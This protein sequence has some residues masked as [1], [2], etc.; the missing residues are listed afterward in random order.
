M[1]QLAANLSTTF[2]EVPLT[3]RFARAAAAG[4]TAAELQFP[5]DTPAE[6]IAAA[7]RTARL[8]IVLI[9]APAGD[10]A[11]GERG[12][13][14][15]GG[16]RFEA[17][18]AHAIA[19]ATRL[20]CTRIHVLIGKHACELDGD[21]LARTA[22]NLHA[23][24][25]AMAQNGITLLLEALNP[26]NEPGYALLSLHAADA[27]RRAT[28]SP[29]VQLQFDAYHAQRRGEDPVASLHRFLPNIAHVQIARA[30]DRAEPDDPATTRFLAALDATAYDGF[31]GCEYTPAGDTQAGLAWAAPYGIR[32][33]RPPI[34][35]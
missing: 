15:A 6:T 26:H 33:A 1:L 30:P 8:A 9:N 4:F 23:A 13:A 3:Q 17:A 29:N 18:I 7:A 2:R 22:A 32:P 10:L 24:A 11:A 20:S 27:L 12:L 16:P 35:G 21:D 28:A 25:A 5:Y 19:Y 14:I 34:S 31:V